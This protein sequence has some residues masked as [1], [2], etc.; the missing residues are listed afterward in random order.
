MPLT[1]AKIR[2]ARPKERAYKL[3]DGEGM[4]LLV[5]SRGVRSWRMKYRRPTDKKEDTLV[6][7]PHPAVSLSEARAERAK[8][9]RLLRSGVDPKRG[10]R[11]ARQDNSLRAVAT[12]CVF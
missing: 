9:K 6:L 7:G 11:T 1:H 3:H 2:N 10:Q 8:A 5:K 12:R 4:Y